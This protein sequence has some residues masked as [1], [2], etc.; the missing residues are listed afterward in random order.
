M[1]FSIYPQRLCAYSQKANAVQK[2]KQ[3]KLS[4]FYHIF[5]AAGFI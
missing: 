4:F 3:D 2:V 1:A 5:L